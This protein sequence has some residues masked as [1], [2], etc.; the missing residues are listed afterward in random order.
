MYK[1]DYLSLSLIR[2]LD[3]LGLYKTEHEASLRADIPAREV[4]GEIM[5]EHLL[6]AARRYLH[7]PEVL[8]SVLV[9]LSHII[10]MDDSKNSRL[11]HTAQISCR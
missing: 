10:R 3:F 11:V 9:G 6:S 1:F 2:P 8:E 5:E 7:R 4:S